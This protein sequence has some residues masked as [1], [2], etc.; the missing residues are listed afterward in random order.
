MLPIRG[1]LPGAVVSISILV[2]RRDNSVSAE[3]LLAGKRRRAPCSP[4][5]CSEYQTEIRAGQ[6]SPC[7]PFAESPLRRLFEAR[8]RPQSSIAPPTPKADFS[9]GQV[10]SGRHFSPLTRVYGACF[11]SG[12]IPGKASRPLFYFG[13]LA[14]CRRGCPVEQGEQHPLSELFP[15]PLAVDDE[16]A[17]RSP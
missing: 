14:A 3:M 10:I 13:G 4:K 8:S 17:N 6:I 16:V 5:L 7:Q 1:P 12:N 2:R 15:S 11:V 9:R